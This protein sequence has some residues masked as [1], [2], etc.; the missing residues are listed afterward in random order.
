MIVKA[1]MDTG[2]CYGVKKCTEIVFR[3]GEGEGL[4]NLEAKMD[5]L[6]PNKKLDLQI[7]GI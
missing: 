5:A 3:K 2:V 7:S 4:T 6:N 1:S